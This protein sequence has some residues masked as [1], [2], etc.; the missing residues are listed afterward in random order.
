MVIIIAAV[1]GW[2]LWSRRRKTRKPTEEPREMEVWQ[3][4]PTEERNEEENYYAT[5]RPG[6][7][8]ASNESQNNYDTMGP[9]GPGPS[10]RARAV[11]ESTYIYETDNDTNQP[12]SDYD[13]TYVYGN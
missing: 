7:W 6:T 9:E 8:E 1:S 5:M 2:C 13:G 11:D 4:G 3:V 12:E 10:N